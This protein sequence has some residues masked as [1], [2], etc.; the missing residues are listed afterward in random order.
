[1]AEKKIVNL[2]KKRAAVIAKKVFR[3]LR[4]PL[5]VLVVAAAG[6][7]AEHH[8]K[9]QDQGQCLLHH[10]CFL[11]KIF[12]VYR[13]IVSVFTTVFEAMAQAIILGIKV[14]MPGKM[15]IKTRIRISTAI[16]GITP[17]KIC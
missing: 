14:A 12:I 2:N 10:L 9:G 5:V 13:L 4:I 17:L 1:M 11:L 7:Q 3:W 6:N 8:H 16:Y 15:I